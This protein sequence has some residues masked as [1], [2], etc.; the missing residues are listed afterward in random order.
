MVPAYWL[1]ASSADETLSRQAHEYGKGSNRRRTG[2]QSR[3]RQE[4]G[5]SPVRGWPDENF[6]P[7]LV[8]GARRPLRMF[9]AARMRHA[10][11]PLNPRDELGG[12]RFI[13]LVR[14]SPL[15][16]PLRDHEVASWM[17]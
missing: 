9:E 12:D 2:S 13:T 8:P 4:A 5:I 16:D 10:Q 7:S 1:S 15:P 14:G 3:A 6:A 11:T 17:L